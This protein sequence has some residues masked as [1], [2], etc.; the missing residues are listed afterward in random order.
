MG[1]KSS[2]L[3]SENFRLDVHLFGITNEGAHQ[4]KLYNAFFYPKHTLMLILKLSYHSFTSSSR[5]NPLLGHARELV[6][7]ADSWGTEPESLCCC[8]LDHQCPGRIP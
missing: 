8:V 4:Y 7:S 2:G 6:A 1:G 5:K 3:D